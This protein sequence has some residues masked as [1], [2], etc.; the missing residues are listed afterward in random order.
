M[1]SSSTMPRYVV[2]RHEMP[3]GGD[4]ASHFDLMLDAGAA[5]RTWALEGEPDSTVEQPVRQLPD[6]RRDYLSYEGPV[7]GNRGNVA[8]WDEGTYATLQDD[9]AALVVDVRG[10][11]LNGVVRITHGGDPRYVYVPGP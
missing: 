5:L 9:E 3:P 1:T 6:H 4:R 8:R 2:L 10:K 7:S 11:R